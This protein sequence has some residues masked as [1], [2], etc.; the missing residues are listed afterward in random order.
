MRLVRRISFVVAALGLASFAPPPEY[1]L[2]VNPS[3]PASAVSRAEAARMFLKKVAAWPD[4][5]TVTAIDQE[6]TSP[7]RQAFSRDIHHKDADGIAA[8]WQTAVFS[9]R[10]VPPPVGRSDDDVLAFV[11]ANPGAI[12]YVSG[13]TAVEG[14]EGVKVLKVQ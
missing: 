5:R 14:V 8:Y 10:D 11:R 3:N 2:V 1:V 13:R 12:G 7:V 4:G 6:R 9:G